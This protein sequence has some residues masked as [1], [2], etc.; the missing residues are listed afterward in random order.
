[1]SSAFVWYELMTSDA[2]AA[3]RFYA[4]LI[5]WDAA[6]S[7]LPGP[8]YT[9][10]RTGGVR[11]AGLMGLP[12]EACEAGATPGWIGY[13]G[14][15]DCDAAAARL[16]E[17]GGTV[18]RPPAD[19]PGIGR[20]A[21]V[22]DKGGAMFALFTPMPGDRTDAQD[23]RPFHPNKQGHCG[24]HELYAA[25][26]EASAFPFYARQFGW[27]ESSRMNMGAMGNYRIFAADG[28]SI[29][30]MMDKPADMPGG[31]WQFYFNVDGIDAAIDRI[32]AGGGTV[33]MGPHLVPG[34][35]W[36][37]Q[38]RDPQGAHFALLSQDR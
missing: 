19:I 28:V 38:A 4:S 3:Q 5:G 37:V 30:G 22:A 18:H 34:D 2:G 21:I 23:G 20:F 13:V 6:D 1:M 15:D 14:V 12:A 32:K 24:W 36:I 33:L 29:G 17:C 31:A 8:A 35:A 25:D 9:I 26:G 27:T 7:G 16:C 11:V 10:L